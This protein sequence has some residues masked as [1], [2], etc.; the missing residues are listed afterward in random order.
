M[1]EAGFEDIWVY[2]T[3]RQNMVVQ[4]IAMRLILDL[5]EQSV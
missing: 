3:R 2:M 5:C 4:Y 1:E